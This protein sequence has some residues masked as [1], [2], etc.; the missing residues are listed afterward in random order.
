MRRI[1]R[2]WRIT[3]ARQTTI[4]GLVDVNDPVVDAERERQERPLDADVEFLSGREIPKP[5]QMM[6]GRSAHL[7]TCALLLPP[8]NLTACH[9]AYRTLKRKPETGINASGMIHSR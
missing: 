5:E 2:L 9:R 1:D 3:P 4:V 6:D 8:R 7:A